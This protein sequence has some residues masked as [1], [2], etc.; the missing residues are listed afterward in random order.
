ME[1]WGVHEFVPAPWGASICRSA[2]NTAG[3]A[4]ALLGSGFLGTARLVT[5]VKPRSVRDLVSYGESKHVD[6]SLSFPHPCGFWRNSSSYFSL[7]RHQVRL[8]TQLHLVECWDQ[9]GNA[10]SIICLIISFPY[11]CFWGITIIQR[12]LAYKCWP[13]IFYR[14]GGKG[15]DFSD[16]LVTCL[17]NRSAC[18]Q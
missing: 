16:S 15:N 4:P 13:W 1:R 18:L 17:G 7:W 11:S 12:V 9:L 6:K 3:A 8:T 2:I 10:L 14:D 5:M